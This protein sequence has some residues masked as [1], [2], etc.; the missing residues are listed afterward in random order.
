MKH[1]Q[2]FS[3]GISLPLQVA[4][5]HSLFRGGFKSFPV[6]L[7]YSLILFLW[8]VVNIAAREGGR[9]PVAW[10]R[11]YWVVEL[12]LNWLLYL[13]ILS[14]VSRAMRQSQH[15]AKVLRWLV[16]AV[17]LFW[18]A[19]LILTQDSQPNQWMT[20][21]AK[22]VAFG[23]ALLNL[24]L[25]AVLVGTHHPDRS[26]LMISGGYGV[27]SAGEAISQSLRALPIQNRSLL[28]FTGNL[29]FVLTNALC[30]AIWWRAVARENAQRAAA[31]P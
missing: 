9:L 29:I 2:W 20:N 22:Y 18:L 6:L 23:G 15:R 13:L 31:I 14:L 30:L 1:L 3:W 8:T 17:G 25:W 7:P 11:A 10:E 24:V 28:V 5:L 26:V 16:F 19:A 4:L 27:Q 21:L 12:I